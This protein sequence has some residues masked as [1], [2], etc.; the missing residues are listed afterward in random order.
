LP[1]PEGGSDNVYLRPDNALRLA[2]GFFKAL[3]LLPFLRAR[4]RTRGDTMVWFGTDMAAGL[5]L[6]AAVILAERAVLTGLFDFTTDYRVVGTFSSMN[7]EG[8]SAP[9]WRWRCRFC[10]SLCCDRTGSRSLRCSVSLSV[11]D[12]F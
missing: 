4:M 7:I 5:A 8:I 1:G 10:W 12:M 6:V 2:K 11:P 9:I 3:A